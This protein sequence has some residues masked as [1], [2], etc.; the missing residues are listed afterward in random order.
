MTYAVQ[1]DRCGSSLCQISNPSP[2]QHSPRDKWPRLLNA[3]ILGFDLAPGWQ[4]PS[5][6]PHRHCRPKADPLASATW[7]NG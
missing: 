5:L 1:K 6:K 7:P 4:Q 3:R 2:T